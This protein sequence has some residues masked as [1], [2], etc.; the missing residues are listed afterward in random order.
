VTTMADKLETLRRQCAN[1]PWVKRTAVESF[2]IGFL[3]AHV[4]EEEWD[5]YVAAAYDMAVVDPPKSQEPS[6]KDASVGSE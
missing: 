4:T 2:L 5:R 1:L 3:Q 6:G